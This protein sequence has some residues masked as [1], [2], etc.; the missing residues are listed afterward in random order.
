MLTQLLIAMGLNFDTFSV[1]IVE[2]SKTKK[3]SIW[4]ALKVGFCFALGQSGMLLIGSFLGIGFEHII[5]NLD[6]WVAFILLGIVG[7]RMIFISDFKT[8]KEKPHKITLKKL[9]PLVVATSIDALIVGVST[10]FLKGSITSYIVFVWLVTYIAAF[11]GFYM[12]KKLRLI[13]K[14][15]VKVIGGIILIGIGVKTLIQHIF[16]GGL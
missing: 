10:A 1:T 7:L 3:N 14:D 5:A 4:T 13:C 15:N 8:E 16:F 11:M 9:A 6:H 2:G 12:G